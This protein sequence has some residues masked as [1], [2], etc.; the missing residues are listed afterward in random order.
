VRLQSERIEPV[1]RNRR[2]H[3]APL[4]DLPDGAIVLHDRGPH[5]VWDKTLLP[6]EPSGYRTAVARP[7][8][9]ETIL[10]T[11]PSLVEL[12]RTGWES[13]LPLIHPSA[14]PAG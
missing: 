1:T 14:R 3:P 10:V 6:W 7:R 9:T 2:L 5:L 13:A 12:L 11:P 8:E 4:D